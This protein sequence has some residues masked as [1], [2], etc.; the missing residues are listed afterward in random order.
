MKRNAA[1]SGS[2][3]KEGW[4]TGAEMT[5]PA[6]Y[7]AA[8]LDRVGPGAHGKGKMEDVI[9]V[10]YPVPHRRWRE[11]RERSILMERCIKKHFN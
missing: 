6:T 4:R 10:S 2:W 1:F 8:T 7:R 5:V 9:N 11:N 3:V